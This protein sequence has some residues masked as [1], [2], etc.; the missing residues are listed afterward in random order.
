MCVG[1]LKTRKQR[2]VESSPFIRVTCAVISRHGRIL[3]A[4]RGPGMKMPGK[5]EFPG[6]KVEAGESEEETICREIQEELSLTIRVTDR[7]P[8]VF[9]D[10]GSFRIELIPFLA[11][12]LSGEAVPSEHDQICWLTPAELKDL[13]W[14]EADLPVMR[15]LTTDAR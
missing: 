2:A 6:G 8:A 15:Q 9:H 3:V 14:A 7:W 5:W 4:R 11:E 10:Y 12:A 1:F 13:D